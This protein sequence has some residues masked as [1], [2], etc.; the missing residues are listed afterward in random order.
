[1]PATARLTVTHGSERGHI[2]VLNG[3]VAH[4]GRGAE[5]QLVL[6]DPDIAEHQAS[7]ANRNGRF[8]IYVSGERPLQINGQPLPVEQWTWL[9]AQAAL[10][11]SDKT[12]LQFQAVSTTDATPDAPVTATM[13]K[14]ERKKPSARK[15]P[16]SKRVIAKFITDQTG[17]TLV[18]LGED[19]QLPELSL[20]EGGKPAKSRGTVDAKGNPALV[21]VALG[22]SVLA[23]ILLLM[24]EPTS[25]T[26]TGKQAARQIILREFVGEEG[27][28][29][30]PY[31][32][33]LRD[34]QLAYARGDRRGEKAACQAVVKLLNSEDR[35]PLTG[36]TG[37]VEDDERLRKLIAVLMGAG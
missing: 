28:P 13:K 19:G 21:Y 1:M 26:K 18:R 10:Q 30:K 15:E 8:A 4:I 5:N 32:R 7:I 2:L 17:D 27:R 31:Q 3:D 36:V 24:W 23:S 6:S 14:A 37:H 35:N 11:L 25:A 22:V 9:P 29:L 33:L 12:A 34:S 16:A 20:S